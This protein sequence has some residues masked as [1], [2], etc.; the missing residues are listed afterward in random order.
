MTTLNFQETLKDGLSFFVKNVASL[1]LCYL[2]YF[3][4]CWIPYLNVGTTI[5][6]TQLPV[7]ISEGKIINPMHI[8]EGKYRTNMGLF[9]LLLS[10]MSVGL[11]FAYSFI[12][13]PGVVLSL[14]WSLAVYYLIDREKGPME[15]LDASNKATLGSKWMIFAI[16]LLLSVLFT[17]V[18]FIVSDIAADSILALIV[19]VLLAL[20]CM[21]AIS[22]GISASIW[23]QLKDNVA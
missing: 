9:F 23:K 7:K 16:G 19:V 20:V 13:I 6:I 1:L 3:L 5:A 12:I 2:L 10:F 14:S 11:T 21:S 15:A 4:T 18:F 22:C 8:F 17:I